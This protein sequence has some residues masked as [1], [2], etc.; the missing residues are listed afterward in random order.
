MMAS[1]IM[2]THP[3]SFK[4]D[5]SYTFAPL[6]PA[7]RE[8]VMAIFNYYIENSMAAYPEHA[9]PPEAF[10][11]VLKMCAGYP[12]ITARDDAGE[13]SGFAMLRPFHPLSTFSGMAEITYFLQPEATGRGLGRLLLDQMILGAREKGLRTLLASISSLNEGSLRF[14]L[15]N[16]FEECGRL[17]RA[18]LKQGREF[19]VIYCQ[20]ML[21][22]D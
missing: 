16:G 8:P 12:A 11:G 1:T 5:R 15:R 17:R 20:L 7:D 4:I 10:D 22:P 3:S 13:L 2:N 9:L 14:H 18:G 19:D 21:I 6:S